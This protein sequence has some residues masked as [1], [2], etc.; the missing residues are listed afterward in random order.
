MTK[1]GQ[2]SIFGVHEARRWESYKLVSLF[3]KSYEVT[4]FFVGGPVRQVQ[5]P[6]HT[7]V[8]A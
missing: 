6:G 4:Y 3:V 5:V 2:F 7:Q 8:V 1:T